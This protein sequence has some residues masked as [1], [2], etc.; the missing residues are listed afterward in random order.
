DGEPVPI[1]RWQRVAAD[2]RDEVKHLLP[3]APPKKNGSRIA[4]VDAGPASL[5]V[6]NDLAPLGYEVVIFEKADKPGGLMRSNIPS[7]RLPERVLDEEIDY[8]LDMG[9]DVRYNSPV[10][11]MNVLLAENFD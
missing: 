9:V 1:C 7:F 2:H 11:S 10:D 3:K 8:I 4:C 6:A 5:T